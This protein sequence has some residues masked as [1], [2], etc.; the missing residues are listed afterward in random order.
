MKTIISI[1]IFALLFPGLVIC[2]NQN[3]DISLGK[4]YF[5]RPFIHA[6]KN[7][8]KG[9]YWLIL[10]EKDNVP[11]FKVLTKKHE[12]LFE[13]RA[14]LA[15]YKG[16]SKKFKYKLKKELLRGYEYF[17]VKVTKPDGLVMAYFLLEKKEEK[18]EEK[19]NN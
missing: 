5:P 4:I 11:Y 16:R 3:V 19:T 17:R 1:T 14:A 8:N 18:K 13:E 2:Q 6:G 15:P 7:Y 12:L 9:V 10:T